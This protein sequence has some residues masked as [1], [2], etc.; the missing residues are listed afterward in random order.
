[1]KKGNFIAF[2]EGQ[3]QG[4]K[5]SLQVI[6]NNQAVLNTNLYLIYGMLLEKE[7]KGNPM[8]P[9]ADTVTIDATEMTFG[10]SGNISLSKYY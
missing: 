5:A 9:N 6:I 7:T 4:L 10:T 8:V 3:A 1:M 2:K